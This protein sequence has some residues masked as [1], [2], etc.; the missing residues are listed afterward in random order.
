M[1]RIRMVGVSVCPGRHN[2]VPHTEWLKQQKCILSQ[3][4]RLEVQ[5]HDVSRVGFCGPR[6]KALF[7][8][9]LVDG[10]LLPVSSC[11]LPSVVVCI[12]VSPYKDTSHTR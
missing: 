6:G 10:P 5:G 8:A 3:C 2:K 12:P 7:P 11:G 4:W 1:L 9:F